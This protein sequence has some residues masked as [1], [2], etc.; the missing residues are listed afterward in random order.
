MSDRNLLLLLSGLACLAMFG[1]MTLGVRAPWGFVL[2]FRGEKLVALILVAL[3][4]STSTVLFQTISFNRIL[5]PAVMGFDALYLLLLTLAVYGLGGIGFTALSPVA[6]FAITSG[7]LVL[8]ALALFGTLLGQARADL[9]RM[10]LTGII[11]GVLFRSITAFLQRMIDP[12][13]FAVIQVNAFARFNTIETDILILAAPI[14]LVA[15]MLSWRMRRRLDV[16]SLGPATATSLGERPKQGQM[17]AL[18]LTAVLVSVSTAFVGPVVFLGLLVVSLAHA[19][20]PTP[21]HAVLLP[22]AGLI[23]VITLVGGQAVLE[24]VLGL[25]TPLSVV[26]DLIGGCV[27]LILVLKGTRT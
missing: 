18:A 2:P 1:F 23:S 19:I 14:T 26:I 3:A 16:I 15:L 22:V 21:Y 11:F 7:V 5:T 25:N 10:I 6:V 17:Q 4:V 24:R 8:A 9:L 13:E 20:R 27:F 12:N